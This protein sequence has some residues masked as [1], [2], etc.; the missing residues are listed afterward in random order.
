MIVLSDG[1]DTGSDRTEEDVIEAA[2]SAG[3]VVYSLKYSSPASLGS[4]KKV[5]AEAVGKGLEHVDHETGGLTF[6]NPGKKLAEEFS[7]IESDLHNMFVLAFAPPPE[8]RD[9]RFHK[10]EVKTTRGNFIVRTRAGY[11]APNGN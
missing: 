5:V 11:W 9:G 3:I 2:Q 8:A 7:R 10:L 6:P 4:I 1:L